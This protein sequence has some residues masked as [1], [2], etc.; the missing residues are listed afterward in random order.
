MVYIHSGI[1]FTQKEEWNLVIC[2]AIARTWGQYIKWDKPIIERQV[3]MFSLTCGIWKQLTCKYNSHLERLWRVVKVGKR[4]FDL[5]TN[6]IS[7]ME[8]SHWIPLILI[9]TNKITLSTDKL[10]IFDE[11]VYFLMSTLFLI[12]QYLLS[13]T[14]LFFLFNISFASHSCLTRAYFTP[15]LRAVY[16]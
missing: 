12:F 4:T 1:L 5:I 6:T 11:P 3:L 15:L 13:N 9:Y 16:I 2:S 7:H 14:N 8:R 10:L